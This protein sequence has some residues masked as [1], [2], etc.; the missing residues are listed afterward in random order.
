M[1]ATAVAAT[2]VAG[3]PAMVIM[4]ILMIVIPPPV[5][6]TPIIATVVVLAIA[7]PIGLMVSEGGVTVMAAS[8]EGGSSSLVDYLSLLKLK[9]RGER[10]SPVRVD[11]PVH[12]PKT[13]H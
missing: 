9:G 1:V 4:M 7:I 5:D 11:L 2:T 8:N 3:A 6:P 13:T 10:P 12:P